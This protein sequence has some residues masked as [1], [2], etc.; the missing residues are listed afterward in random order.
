MM[1]LNKISRKLTH[2]RLQP[3]Q[4]FLFHQVSDSYDAALCKKCDWSQVDEFKAVLLGLKENYEFLSLSQALK[5]LQN[6]VF[7]TKKYAVL[8]NDDGSASLKNILPWLKEQSIP[9]TLFVNAK[10]LDGVSFRNSPTEEYLTERELFDLDYDGIEIAHHGWEHNDVTKMDWQQFV[11][12]AE[13]NLSV[14]HNH[15]RYAPFWAYTWGRHTQRHD[16]Y[17]LSKGIVPVLIDGM[18]NY[19]DAACIHREL[20]DGAVNSIGGQ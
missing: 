9:V 3:I 14:L 19:N 15:P 18:K 2:L 12:A 20:L 16:D 4:V 5:H 10:Y 7:R 11:D 8:T 1:K 13:R 17:L 6:D